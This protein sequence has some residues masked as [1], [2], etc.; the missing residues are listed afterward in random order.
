[1]TNLE[2][3]NPVILLI[4][5]IVIAGAIFGYRYYKK[6]IKYDVAPVNVESSPVVQ[7]GDIII[8]PEAKF[9]AYC[10]DAETQKLLPC[11]INKPMGRQLYFDPSMPSSGWKFLIRKNDDGVIEDYEPRNEPLLS[12]D[13]PKLAYFATHWDVV[14]EVFS[15]DYSVWRDAKTW[16]VAVLAFGAFILSLVTVAG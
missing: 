16:I 8:S 15:Y 9:D 6:H 3:I 10:F 11:K 14:A 13:T 5:I 7:T 1:M 12:R 4:G 2:M